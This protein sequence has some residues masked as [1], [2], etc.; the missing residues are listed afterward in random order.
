MPSC[1]TLLGRYEPCKQYVGGIKGAFF[2]PFE[3]ANTIVTDGAGLI[4]QINNGA[5]TP[6]K[7]T[8]YFWELK[9][10]STLE[11]TI[12][13][14]R[15]NGTTMYESIFTLSFKPSGVTPA[16]GDLDMDSIQTLSKGRWQIVIWDRNDQFWLIGQ[17]LGC[18][19]NGGSSS[20]GVQMGDARLN[21]ITFSSQEKNPPSP[22]DADNYSEL[23]TSVIIVSTAP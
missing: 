3:F 12:T 8:G 10:L 5:A 1:G 16:A 15:D 2:I 7:V 18:D 6:V 17:T 19:A 14:S 20:W 9:G 4:T 13:A 22:I 11:T 23:S 21:T